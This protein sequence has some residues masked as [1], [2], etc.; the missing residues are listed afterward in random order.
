MVKKE[1][2][3]AGGRL[4]T[5]SEA[6]RVLGVSEAALRQWT[7]EGKVKAFITPGGHRRY[8]DS[9]LRQLMQRHRHVHGL[10]DLGHRLEGVVPREREVAQEYMRSTRWYQGLD[11]TARERL[12]ERGRRLVG[13]L[14]S[15]VTRPSTRLQVAEEC[16]AIG[17]EYGEDLAN[18][19]L[20]LT[21]AI[22]AFILHRTPLTEATMELLSNSAPMDKR[23]L[24]AIPQINRLIDDTLLALVEMHQRV[25]AERMSSSPGGA[26]L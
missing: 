1:L 13:A 14:V 22:E 11:D 26:A 18:L 10:R 7:D 24:T 2:K 21:D 4:L 17:R 23:A 3:E 5:I 12:R 9:E 8:L 16:R 20:S 6:C 19:G 25:S 15:F